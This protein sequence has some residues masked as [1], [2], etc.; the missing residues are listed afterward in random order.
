MQTYDRV[1]FFDVRG[2]YKSENI[3]RIAVNIKFAITYA[4]NK[5]YGFAQYDA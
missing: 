4:Y 5:Y 3:N 1:K 2:E